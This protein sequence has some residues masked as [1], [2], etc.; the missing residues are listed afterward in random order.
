MG[1]RF[2]LLNLLGAL[3]VAS[4]GAAAL[5]KPNAVWLSIVHSLLLL[6]VL[7]AAFSARFR[8]D[9]ANAFGQGFLLTAA[10][11]GAIMYMPWMTRFSQTLPT[12][13]LT[14]LLAEK[15]HGINVD[16]PGTQLALWNT[17]SSMNVTAFGSS[18]P[19]PTSGTVSW[20]ATSPIQ[21]W[22]TGGAGPNARFFQIA[23]ALW[24][25]L[26][27]FGGGWAGAWMAAR[28]ATRAPGARGE[29]AL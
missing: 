22:T 16:Q 26:F 3:L 2:T 15:M 13:Y 6:A 9:P 7:A 5:A 21:L 14:S 1:I 12:V 8:P 23:Q 18:L 17:S 28:T 19:Q 29:A 25:L 10:I 4:I 20:V 24:T 27:G 11:Y